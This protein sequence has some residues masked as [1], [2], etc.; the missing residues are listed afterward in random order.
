MASRKT[1]PRIPLAVND[2]QV[3]HCKTPNCINFGIVAAQKVGPGYIKE[4]RYTISGA[5]RQAR[6]LACRA[7]GRTTV[8]RSNLAISQERSRLD[9]RGRRLRVAACCTH[10]CSSEGQ[11]ISENPKLYFLHGKTKAGEPRYRCKACGSTFTAGA[12]FRT[13]RRPEL[14]TM[15]L[16]HLVNK[17]PMRRICETLDIN[18]ATLYSKIEYL[19]EAVI[20][21]SAEAEARLASG[22]HRLQRAYVSVDR[23]DHVLNWGSQLDRRNTMLGSVGA[24]E[25]SSG[26]VL[27]MQ[28]N[29]DPDHD[30]QD[31]EADAISRGDY[32]LPPVYRHYARLWLLKDYEN[33][34]SEILEGALD[35]AN[36][37]PSPATL[38]APRSGM[39][40]RLETVHFGV[41]FYLKR[42]L[43][44]VEKVRF[45]LDRDPGLDS[46]CLSA[47]VDEI[48]SRQVDV[49][50][51]K[52]N[53]IATTMAK[54]RAVSQ[55]G[56]ELDRFLETHPVPEGES[57]R[58]HFVLDRLKAFQG[59]T[60]TNGWFV[61]P[62]SDMADSGKEVK[63]LTNFGDM[64]SEHMA[65]LYMLAS[66][67]GVD[68]FF[69]QVRR[70]LSVMERPIHSP[71][72][73]NRSWYGYAAYSPAVAQHLLNI[74]R[75]YTNFCLVG[76]DRQTPAMRLGL[77]AQPVPLEEL[78]KSPRARSEI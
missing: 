17:M 18:P 25:N 52:V 28:L 37:L 50:Q 70:R 59:S 58:F 3:N 21:Y 10:G 5:M 8:L 44:H 64:D 53:K 26:Y 43:G 63:Q 35:T 66:L 48:K 23:Q 16:M 75:V 42:L 49:F 40:V 45:F 47:F 60:N 73:A 77:T 12:P 72:N 46:A 38:K 32:D 6:V 51:I 39:Q 30:P 62:L 13:Q 68:R 11:S 7:C 41:F 27:A 22:E 36:D 15:V 31:V 14:D 2:I 29:F 34:S 71:S 56:R 20:R 1:H 19:A 54:K 61:Y 74:L 65:R 4:D 67:R 33:T 69:M 9:P 76:E 57:P 55:T 78:V 24:V